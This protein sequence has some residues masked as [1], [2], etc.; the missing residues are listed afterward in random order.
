MAKPAVAVNRLQTLEVALEITTQITLDK[1]VIGANS[2]NDLVDLLYGE[3]LRAN[4]WVN[5]G[6]FQD[7]LRPG[8]ADPVNVRERRFDAFISGDF[9]SK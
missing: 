2:L 3:I 5:I 7:L 8:R 1:E 6:L 9:N 4:L